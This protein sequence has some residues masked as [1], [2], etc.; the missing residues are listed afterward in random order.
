MLC[1]MSRNREVAR[2]LSEL[3]LLTELDEGSPQAFRVRAYENA[4]RAVDG[5]ATDVAALSERELVA[6]KGIGKST[7]Q[8][9]AEY[10]ET[11]QIAKLERLRERFPPEYVTSKNCSTRSDSRRVAAVAATGRCAS[12]DVV[13]AAPG[14]RAPPIGMA[15]IAP[16]PIAISRT[17][18]T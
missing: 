4:A 2:V 12:V 18:R 11:G 16:P 14:R 5:L 10:L 9:I 6:T 1:G 13:A 15:P 7:A 17:A 8:K 3:A